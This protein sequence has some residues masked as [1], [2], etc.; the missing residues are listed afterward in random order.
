MANIPVSELTLSNEEHQ[1]TSYKPA[2]LSLAVLYFMMGFI[3]CLN[4]TLVPF[5]KKGFDLSYS[6]SSLVQFYFFLTYG[7]MSIPAGKI[8]QKVGYKAGMV[9]G[10]IIASLGAALFFPAALLHEYYLFLGALFVIAIGIV[11]LQVAANPYI[12]ILGPAQTASSR[13]TLIQGVGSIGTTLAPLFGAAFI[14]GP[15]EQ[16]SSQAVHYPYLGISLVLLLIAGVVWKLKLPTLTTSNTLRQATKGPLSY[17]HLRYG[18]AGLFC[19]VGAEVSVGTFLT[20]YI[21]DTLH[22]TENE[23]N[24]FVAFYWGGM[25]VGRLVGS[26]VLK[27]MAPSRLLTALGLASMGLILSSLNTDGYL[28]IGSMIALGVCNSVMFAIIF[29]LSVKDLGA[30]TSQASGYLSTAIAGGA[31]VS[32]GQGYLIDHYSWSIAFLLPLICYAYITFFGI[33][34]YKPEQTPTA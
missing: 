11:L 4:D 1:G 20:N 9:R 32:F 5:F 3:T 7:L 17:R 33:K 22:I 2:L 8:V 27:V 23:A 28:A 25:L 12:T 16:A 30:D 21:A 18:I 19:Y 29:S 15:L 10:F 13:L 14:L 6:Q 24:T 34:G 26:F 31:I